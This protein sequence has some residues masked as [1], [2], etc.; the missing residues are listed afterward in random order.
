MCRPD[1]YI[2]LRPDQLPLGLYKVIERDCSYSPNVP[3]DCSQTR[4]IELVKG[5]FR[6]L[7]KDEVA[8]ATWLSNN[9]DK[10]HVFNVRDLRNGKF[11]DQHEYVIE[12]DSLGKEW[13]VVDGEITDYFFVRYPRKTP[14]G[15]MAGR[16]HLKLHRVGRI[17]KIN[18]LLKYPGADD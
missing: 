5:A 11:V 18:R 4:Y 17:D 8:F 3:E 7:D 10:E 16:T 15:D 12:D 2:L 1:T 6:S 14:V 13:F 9:P